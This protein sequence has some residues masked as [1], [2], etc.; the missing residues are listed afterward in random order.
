[1]H[2]VKVICREEKQTIF[3][4]LKFAAFSNVFSRQH[5]FLSE[6]KTTP[7]CFHF[8]ILLRLRSP[9]K[10]ELFRRTPQFLSQCVLSCG[11]YDGGGGG[12]GEAR[13]VWIHPSSPQ[14]ALVQVTTTL[15]TPRDTAEGLGPRSAPGRAQAEPPFSALTWSPGPEP[16]QVR[17]AVSYWPRPLGGSTCPRLEN[18][19]ALPLALPGWLLPGMSAPPA[20]SS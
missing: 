19:P 18:V 17:A 2:P 5:V 11:R 3:F 16:P 12:G 10:G 9:I 15:G 4:L 20:G 14:G 8:K 13:T 7:R 6:G 1:M